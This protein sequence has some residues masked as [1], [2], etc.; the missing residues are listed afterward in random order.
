MLKAR[1]LFGLNTSVNKN[2]SCISEDEILYPIGGV[3]I[4]HNYKKK[5]QRYINLPN[6]Q[7]EI[8]VIS[9]SLKG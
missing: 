9:V 8:S 5:S 1:M 6:P 2:I 4:I 3:I 7:K